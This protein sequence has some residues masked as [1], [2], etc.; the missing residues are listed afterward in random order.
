MLVHASRLTG[1][2]AKL[3]QV[4]QEVGELMDVAVLEGL[5][6]Q[7]RQAQL[8]AAGASKTMNSKHL[9]GQAVD[10]GVVVG[11]DVRWDWPLYFKLAEAVQGVARRLEVPIRWGGCWSLLNADQSPEELQDA[12]VARCKREGRRPFLDGPHFEVVDVAISA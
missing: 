7:A 9:V 3:V 10:L 6:T 4:V 8:V 2:N 5:R 11:R 12:Y 1:V